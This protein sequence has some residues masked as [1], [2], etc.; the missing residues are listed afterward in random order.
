VNPPESIRRTFFHTQHD[1]VI[2][3]ARL[4]ALRRK[5]LQDKCDPDSRRTRQHSCTPTRPRGAIAP[6]LASGC[7]RRP[8]PVDSREVQTCRSCRRSAAPT[9]SQR[10]TAWLRMQSGTTSLLPFSLITGNFTGNFQNKGLIGQFR[11][12]IP[13]EIQLLAEKFPTARNREFFVS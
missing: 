10:P 8:V 1:S 5:S 3:A 7:H 12:A 6:P 4:S 9:T 11:S 13:A 2:S